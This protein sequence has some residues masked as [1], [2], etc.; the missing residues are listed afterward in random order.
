MQAYPI[1]LSVYDMIVSSI[2]SN[3]TNSNK[4]MQV[5]DWKTKRKFFLYSWPKYLHLVFQSTCV[6]KTIKYDMLDR[7]NGRMPL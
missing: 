3:K 2:L 6:E 4:H 7:L 1:P 5:V